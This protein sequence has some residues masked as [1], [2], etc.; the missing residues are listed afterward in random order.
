MKRPAAIAAGYHSAA[1]CLYE[2]SLYDAQCRD[3]E[4]SQ[5]IRML[6]TCLFSV[7]DF[8][9]SGS[10]SQ[11]S[12]FP[13]SSLVSWTHFGYALLMAFKLSLLK[14]DGW[15]LDQAQDEIQLPRILEETTSSLEPIAK[16]RKQMQMQN[17]H[18]VTDNLDERD[19]FDRFIRQMQR[20]K[21]LSMINPHAVADAATEPLYTAPSQITNESAVTPSAALIDIMGAD[22]MLPD[23]DQSFW[24][25]MYHGDDDPWTMLCCDG[26]SIS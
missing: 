3:V 10:A 6:S 4:K 25:D 23:F 21:S 18:A 19:I 11:I 9:A 14:V 24:Q 26:Q 5:R 17:E 22:V 7:K 2:A 15:D 12:S 16:Q 1:I 13:A 20:M 8:F